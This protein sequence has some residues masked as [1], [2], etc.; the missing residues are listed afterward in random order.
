MFNLNQREY[1]S[2]TKMVYILRLPY[3]RGIR[4]TFN[5]YQWSYPSYT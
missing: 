1:L 2:Y 4:P 5:L 3:T